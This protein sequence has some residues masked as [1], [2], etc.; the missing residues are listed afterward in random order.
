MVERARSRAVASA[1]RWRARP[2]EP[3]Q[4]QQLGP[5]RG[6]VHDQPR[7]RAALV[8]AAYLFGGGPGWLFPLYEQVFGA[9]AGDQL[10]TVVAGGAG[11]PATSVGDLVTIAPIARSGGATSDA[12]RRSAL[13]YW[14]RDARAAFRR[15]PSAALTTVRGPT[16]PCRTGAARL[17]PNTA[18]AFGAGERP[19]GKESGSSR[20]P[21]RQ[22]D[23]DAS[24]SRA[25]RRP[26]VVAAVAV[27]V[28]R[29][30][31]DGAQVAA[32]RV[33]AGDEQRRK[34]AAVGACRTRSALPK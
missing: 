22:V 19:A 13:H 14:T 17:P 2:P 16:A 12:V 11:R 24:R 20:A 26:D 32:R 21:P 10:G 4:L 31:D 15:P 9:E 34:R 33:V 30:G 28:A 5:I 25:W 1:P 23:V 29:R 7:R 3:A 18:V 8:G 6:R 27:D